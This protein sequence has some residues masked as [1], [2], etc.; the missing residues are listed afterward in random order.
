MSLTLLWSAEH[1]SSL[2]CIT[3]GWSE[4]SPN[5]IQTSQYRLFVT[6]QG[7]KVGTTLIRWDKDWEAHCSQSR[8]V[9]NPLAIIL[10]MMEMY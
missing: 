4:S 7:V 6:V 1:P 5:R 10:E 8:G 9:N 3:A 2:T